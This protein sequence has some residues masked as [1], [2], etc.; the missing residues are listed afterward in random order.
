MQSCEAT[1]PLD[2]ILHHLGL[3]VKAARLFFPCRP[4]AGK[5]PE[6][7]QKSCYFQKIPVDTHGGVWYTAIREL[8][9][10]VPETAGDAKAL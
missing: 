1:T 9:S 6:I 2:Y 5:L 7:V 8:K 4:F 3:R 10:S